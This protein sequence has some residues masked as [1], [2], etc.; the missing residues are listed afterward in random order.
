ML[1]KNIVKVQY[2]KSNNLFV[3]GTLLVP[4]VM[5]AVTGRAFKCA[6]ATLTGFVRYQVRGQVF[7]GIIRHNDMEVEGAVYFSIDTDSLQ[8][9]DIFE[10]DI[11][12]REAVTVKLDNNRLITAYTYT[13]SPGH[14]NILTNRAWDLEQFKQE[15]LATYLVHI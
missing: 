10:S 4:A 14:K 15:H 7:P 8:R 13:V 2:L 3:Y 12:S 5:Q 9:L 11:Y 1:N 6:N